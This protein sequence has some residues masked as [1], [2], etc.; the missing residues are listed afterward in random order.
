MNDLKPN[1]E[2]ARNAILLLWIMFALEVISFISSY[3]QYDL[4]QSAAAGNTISPATANANDLRE[5]VI[6]IITMIGYIISAVTFIQW[7]RRAYFNLHQ[8]A[9]VLSYTEDTAAYC[10]FIPIQNLYTPYRVMKELYEE[11]KKIL[12]EQGYT[13]N[14][15]LDTTWVGLW[16]AFWVINNFISQL[17]FRTSL[18]AEGLDELINVTSLGLVSN[19][20][21]IPLAL[22]AIK[23]VKDYADVEYLLNDIGSLIDEIKK[24]DK[25]AALS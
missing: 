22:L 15:R 12:A 17:V 11:T 10:W 8:R 24:D 7:F 25:D 1:A 5:Q 21:G 14:I 13:S 18:K 16:W 9:T 19:L 6:A 4:L 20:I 23:V 3:L 2:R